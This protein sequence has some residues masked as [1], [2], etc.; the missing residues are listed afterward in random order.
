MNISIT[1]ITYNSSNTVIATLD[2]ILNQD[3]KSKSLELIISDDGSKDDTIY[4]IDEWLNINSDEFY[5]VKFIKNIVN[6]GVSVNCNK[7]WKAATSEWIKTIAGDDI[8]RP[9]C[10]SDNIKFVTN[11]HECKIVFSKMQTFGITNEIIPTKFDLR[12]FDKT[13]GEQNTYLKT[14]SFNIAP[15]SFINRKV[16]EQVGYADEKYKMIEDLPLW[17]KFTKAGYKLYFMDSITVNYR[18]EASITVSVDKCA[19]IPFLH[20]LIAI[21]K[22]QGSYSLKNPLVS[23]TRLE[24][25]GHLY[26]RLGVAKVFKNK[27]SLHSDRLMSFSW[28][29]RPTHVNQAVFKKYYNFK[30]K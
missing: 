12:F 26:Y 25:L 9:N 16:L 7:A 4:V 29:F 27:R 21:N 22:D 15:S 6:R 20:D 11:N 17:L 30:N 23:L 8:L 14:F 1:V 24:G 2:S 3:Y 18:I 10:I 13:S 28:V 19:N 5:D